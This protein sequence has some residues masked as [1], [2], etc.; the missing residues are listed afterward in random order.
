MTVRSQARWFSTLFVVMAAASYQA[1]ARADAAI[2]DK[3][4]QEAKALASEGKFAEA[5]PKF[6]ASYAADAALGAILNLADCLEREG[7]LASAFGRW[8]EAVEQADR[9]GDDRAAFARERREAL[10]PK[11]SFVTVQV[12]GEAAGLDVYKGNTKLQKGA[13]GVALPTDPGEAV[14][15]VVRGDAVV[16]ERTVS[17]R[18]AE[19]TT[20]QVDLAEIERANPAPVKKRVELR[21]GGGK[22]GEAPAGFWSGQRVA[23]LVVALAGVAGAGVGFTLGGLAAAQTSD[24]DAGCTSGDDGNIRLC[25]PA[26]SDAA[27]QAKSLA[28]GSTWTLIASGIVAGV[29]LTVFITAPS[30]AAELDERAFVS[31]WVTPQGAGVV[32]GGTF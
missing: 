9:K 3:L 15:Q 26:G 32:V 20:V 7:R 24:I 8:G 31:P 21:E 5:C 30:E 22:A 19:S 16:W 27:S 12:A 2:A 18:E 25:T 11:L 29:G 6:E 13:F 10:R 28:D 14:V 4:F 23:G 1:E 17:L